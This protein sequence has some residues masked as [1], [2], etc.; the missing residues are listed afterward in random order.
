[1]SATVGVAV[2]LL[3]STALI[4]LFRRLRQPFVIAEISAGI[5]LGPSVLGLLPGD[6]PDRIFPS[7]AR[8]SLSAIAELGILLFMFLVGWQ[9]NPD[10]IVKRP[11]NVLAVSLS[12]LALPLVLG[13]GAALWLYQNH[14][15]V[16]GQPVG[17]LA[18]V[19]FVGTAM[20]I[21]AFPVLARIILEHRLQL[22]P[23]GRL[24]LACAAIGDV[25]AW[26]ILAVGSAVAASSGVAHALT[27]LGLLV[28]YALLLR[29][30]VRPLLN[31]LIT[32]MTRNGEVSPH[33]F[34]LVA[35]GVLLSAYTTQ[36][37]GLDAIFG[38]FAFGLV[39]PRRSGDAALR[40]RVQTPAEHI[41]ALLL[42]VFFVTTGLS[43]DITQL[44]GSGLI[45]LLVIC[46]IACIGKIVGASVPARLTG[47]SWRDAGVV[48]VLM[49]TRGLTELIILNAGV[50]MGI[51]DQR[52]Y[53]MMVV[54]ALV[55][56]AM[57]GPLV[58]RLPYAR[59]GENQE[60]DVREGV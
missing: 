14:A 15:T 59:V 21:T 41:T 42:P 19:L 43:I 57:A 1:M 28:P 24:S 6:L 39:M 16:D 50:S 4:P 31:L 52:M 18:F 2:V 53:T 36:L 22:S 17:K 12:S 48:G 10:E 38:A 60:S 5:A 35:A 9:M 45:E 49:N 51:L 37:I 8:T 23:V 13:S 29:F 20:A 40:A 32:R 34:G 55:T 3:V 7:D 11:G 30:A 25:L 54:M 33:V 56:T 27:V 26:C 47:M 46:A 58:P 44:G